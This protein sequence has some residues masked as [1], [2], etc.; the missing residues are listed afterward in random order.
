VSSEFA[1]G[2]ESVAKRCVQRVPLDAAWH[3]RLAERER[4][5]ADVLA[6]VAAAARAS[7]STSAPRGVDRLVGVVPMESSSVA[8]V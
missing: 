8:V 5:A 7:I 4:G 3:L 6:A 1:G 2:F